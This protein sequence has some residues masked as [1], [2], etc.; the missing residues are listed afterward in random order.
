[1]ILD[2][3]KAAFLGWMI[4][5]LIAQVLLAMA[6][7]LPNDPDRTQEEEDAM[8][9][10]GSTVAITHGC[11]FFGIFILYIIYKSNES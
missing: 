11:I 4:L 7:D 9:V 8:R 3:F 5:G 6:D 10:K 2:A 1:M